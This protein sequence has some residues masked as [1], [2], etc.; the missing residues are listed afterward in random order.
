MRRGDALAFSNLTCHASTVNSTDQM[1]WSI[2]LR[3]VVPETATARSDEERHGYATIYGPLPHAADHRDQPRPGPS[4][5]WE[6]I[7]NLI[8]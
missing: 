4:R 5:A 8:S 2:D 3:Y 1:R 6:Q 7:R